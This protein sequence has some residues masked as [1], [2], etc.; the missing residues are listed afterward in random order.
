[1]RYNET[2]GEEIN[3]KI[4]ITANIDDKPIFE[5]SCVVVGDIVASQIRANFDLTIVGEVKADKIEVAGN[6][7]CLGNCECEEIGVQGACTVEGNLN[8]KSGFI[9][10]TLLAKDIYAECLDAKSSILCINLECDDVVTCDEFALIAEGLTGSGSLESK[11]SLCGEYSMLDE[12]SGVFIAD[13]L[14]MQKPGIDVKKTNKQAFNVDEWKQKAISMKAPVF[15]SELCKLVEQN[16]KFK[17]ECQAFHKL[18]LVEN[19]TLIPSIKTYIDIM[20]IVN[21]Q[22]KII[23]NTKLYGKV[24]AKFESFDVDDVRGAKLQSMTQKDFAKIMYVITMR[25]QIFN[26]D[27][28]ELLF[29]TLFLYLD[30]D[31]KKVLEKL[32]GNS[33]GIT[34]FFDRKGKSYITEILVGDNVEVISGVWRNTVGSVIKVDKV[35]KSVSIEV[36]L[37]G[38]KTPVDIQIDDCKKI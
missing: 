14:E 22:F 33:D 25:P 11:M 37:F 17:G 4:V 28:R 15:Y 9:G 12:T 26:D 23:S 24:K 29:E 27:I 3:G 1:L 8:V 20:D 31:Y 13:T 21:K 36:E 18:M 2:D 38:R 5:T 19:I 16:E 6:F 32:G 30:V 10:E 35:K 7:V 34:D